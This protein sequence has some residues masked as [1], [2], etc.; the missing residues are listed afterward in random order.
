MKFRIKEKEVDV[1]PATLRQI[2]RLEK[3]VGN[4]QKL[5]EDAPFETMVSMLKEILDNQP[6]PNSTEY[7][8]ENPNEFPFYFEEFDINN[9]GVINATVEL[10][11]WSDVVELIYLS[12]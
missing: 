6:I 8:I 10:Q 11:G 3:Q 9:D 1:Q 4:V 5:T 12:F 7:Y 2:A